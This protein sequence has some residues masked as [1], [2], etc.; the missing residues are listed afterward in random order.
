MSKYKAVITVFDNDGN[1]VTVN[2]IE[3]ASEVL[4][5]INE[6]WYKETIFDFHVTSIVNEDNIPIKESI[7]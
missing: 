4:R 3:P 7:Q 1:I 5:R 2:N 6:E